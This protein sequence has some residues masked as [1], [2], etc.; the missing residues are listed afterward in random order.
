M[1]ELLFQHCHIAVGEAKALCIYCPAYNKLLSVDF[2]CYSV[3]QQSLQ[4]LFL[5]DDG[6]GETDLEHVEAPRLLRM[7]FDCCW[8]EQF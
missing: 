1:P 7:K 3:R 4:K 5:V 2:R 8:R 6:S